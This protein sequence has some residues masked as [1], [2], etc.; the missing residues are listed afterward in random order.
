MI[1]PAGK[2]PLPSHCHVVLSGFGDVAETRKQPVVVE[3]HVKLHRSLGLLVVSPVEQARAKLDH[4][5]VDR[6]Q[7]ILEPQPVLRCDLS[8][9]LK[10][11][12][13]NTLVQLPRP[14][15]VGV[16]QGGLVWRL[17]DAEMI[18]L[19]FHRGQPLA[20]LTKGLSL[21][22]LAKQHRHELLPARKPSRVPLGPGLS[23]QLL[24][25]CPWKQ[26]ENLTEHAREC[27]QRRASC[28]IVVLARTD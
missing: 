9:A 22:Q 7:R 27:A 1:V 16:R 26:L 5:G 20:D 6:Q 19:P 12:L 8:A 10:Q 23:Y 28:R 2:I 11:L 21:A 4:R 14:V 17:L 18:E 24:E 25:L 15:S 13:E 3:D